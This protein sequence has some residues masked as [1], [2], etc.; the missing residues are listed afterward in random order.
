MS[1]RF[2]YLGSKQQLYRVIDLC[3]KDRPESS[4]IG[5]ISYRA[6]MIYPTK[7]GSDASFMLLEFVSL[8]FKRAA[9]L[10]SR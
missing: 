1:E 8:V 5:L 4:V 9:H 10:M 2:R 3:S 7:P 6:Y